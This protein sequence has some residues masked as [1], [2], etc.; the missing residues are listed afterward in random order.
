[1]AAEYTAIAPQTVAANDIVKFNA[2]PVWCGRNVTSR[3]DSGL[4]TLRSC[5]CCER[6]LVLFSAN[7]AIP[8]GGTVEEIS[9]ALSLEGEPMSS[10]IMS[11]TPAAVENFFNVST[12]IFIDV[13]CGCCKSLSVKNINTQAITVRNANIIVIRD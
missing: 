7:I 5:G 4:I 12:S 13:D 9:L 8:T 2:N 6:Y 1:M 3:E 11:V 10:T